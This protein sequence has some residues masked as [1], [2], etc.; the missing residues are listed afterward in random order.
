MNDDIA[1]IGGNA[2]PS[3]QAIPWRD[4]RA[5]ERTVVVGSMLLQGNRLA[6]GIREIDINSMVGENFV[7]VCRTVGLRH[8]S[9]IVDRLPWPVN[10]TIREEHCMLVWVMLFFLATVKV[11]LGCKLLVLVLGENITSLAG[12]HGIRNG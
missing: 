3:A 12:S 9:L 11:C 7:T 4:E 1:I 5:A 6:V 8:S 2:H 10:R